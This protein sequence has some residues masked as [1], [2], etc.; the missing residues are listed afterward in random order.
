MEQKYI[1]CWICL[2]VD[3]L[4]LKISGHVGVGSIGIYH[5]LYGVTSTKYK[6]SRFLTTNFLCKEKN[7]LTFN[8][9]RCC[10]L[11]LCIW[12]ILFHWEFIRSIIG[13][14]LRSFSLPALL[15]RFFFNKDSTVCVHGRPPPISLIMCSRLFIRC[16][17]MHYIKYWKFSYT[18]V[19][20]SGLDNKTFYRCN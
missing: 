1:K 2:F 18:F 13:A 14:M 10:H 20:Y 7:T 6:L 11:A 16:D 12:L 3:Q 4:W 19:L 17:Q 5:L 8:R 15:A 9:D